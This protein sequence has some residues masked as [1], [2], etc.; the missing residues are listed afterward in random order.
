MSGYQYV[1][2]SETVCRMEFL[3]KSASDMIAFRKI[4]CIYLRAKFSYLPKQISEITGLSISRV[5]QIHTAY[6]KLGESVLKETKRGGRNHCYMDEAN[7]S[8]ILES[9]N[10]RASQG[11][12]V[13]VR[14]I[15]KKYEEVLQKKVTKSAI[16]KILHRHCWRKVSP[17]PHHPKH[18][19]D[20]MEA[21]KK[22]SAQ[23][24]PP[25][26]HNL[27]HRDLNYK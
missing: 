24:L 20:E 11:E 23:W 9:F 18:N 2:P 4:Q 8:K 10:H 21:F 6:Y 14:E 19:K 27:N 12:I 13:V 25:Q 17:R 3:L 15:Q 7:E 16:Y 5:R 22:T 1:Y 26:I